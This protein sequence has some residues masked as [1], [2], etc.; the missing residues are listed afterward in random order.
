VNQDYHA[1]R[2]GVTWVTNVGIDP[3]P[4]NIDAPSGDMA[5][6]SGDVLAAEA[7][8]IPVSTIV[9]VYQAFGQEFIPD[10]ASRYYKWPGWRGEQRLLALWKTLV[11][12][13]AFDY[14]YGWENQDSANPTLIN[15]PATQSVFKA[16]FSSERNVG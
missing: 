8:W 6:V 10:V 13:P 16:F 11:P 1:L 3:Y 12:H 5:T 9:P 14:T 7:A 4:F 15:S 2:P